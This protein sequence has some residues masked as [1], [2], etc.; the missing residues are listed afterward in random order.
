[1]TDSSSIDPAVRGLRLADVDKGRRR[2]RG[3]GRGAPGRVVPSIGH[4]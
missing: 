3:L 2:V 1:M 4:S